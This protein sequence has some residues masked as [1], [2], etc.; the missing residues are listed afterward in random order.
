M[1]RV[2]SVISVRASSALCMRAFPVPAFSARYMKKDLSYALALAEE[3]GVDAA[4]AKL[5]MTRLDASL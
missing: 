1:P 5:A 4:A 2:V 3:N